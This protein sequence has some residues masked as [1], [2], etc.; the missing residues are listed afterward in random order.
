VTIETIGVLVGLA[1]ALGIAW[2]VLRSKQTSATIELLRSELTVEKDA[3]LA[4][5]Q[6]CTDQMKEQ[7]RRHSVEIAELRGQVSAM[8][9]EFARTLAGLLREN[10]VGT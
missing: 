5:E 9:P 1:A 6:R 3:R 10:G 7:D 2:P 4:Q 8:T